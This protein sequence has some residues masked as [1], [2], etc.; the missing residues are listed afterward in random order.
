MPEDLARAEPLGDLPP[1]VPEDLAYLLF[2]SGTTGEP[3]G[4]G[5]THGNRALADRAG[6]IG[7]VVMH[8]QAALERP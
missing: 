2:T 7:R 5:V 6:A 4:V 8:L 3:K 1:V